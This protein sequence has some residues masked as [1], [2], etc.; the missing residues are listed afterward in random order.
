MGQLM[1]NWKH[2][3]FQLFLILLQN[4]LLFGSFDFTKVTEVDNKNQL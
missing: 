4:N 1:L 2:D 3:S